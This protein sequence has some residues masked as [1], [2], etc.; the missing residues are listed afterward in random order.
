MLTS[1]TPFYWPGSD[2]AAPTFDLAKAGALLDQAGWT[3]GSGGTRAKNGQ[4]L[5]LPL[6]IINDSTTVLQ[7][8]ILD[9]QLAKAGIKVDTKPLEQTAWFA[10]AR[11]GER[12]LGL[13]R[14]LPEQY[15]L[16]IGRVLQGDLGRSLRSR[17][18]LLGDVMDALPNTL[19]LAV[20]AAAITP[21]LS[22]ACAQPFSAPGVAMAR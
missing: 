4:Q 3:R 11:S 7:A 21:L 18:P 16:Y 1:N 14:P 9:Q 6:L 22:T 15:A 12:E 5:V 20:A 10:T 13:D 19:Q 17:R 8:Q 2:Q